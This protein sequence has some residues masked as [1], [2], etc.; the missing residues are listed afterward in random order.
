MKIKEQAY[1]QVV[2]SCKERCEQRRGQ[3]LNSDSC[4]LM[5]TLDLLDN[6]ADL[7]V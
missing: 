1:E 6:I 3:L 7:Y 5:L 2:S 4:D